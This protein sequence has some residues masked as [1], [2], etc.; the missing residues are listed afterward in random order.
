M[1][2]ED[3]RLSKSITNNQRYLK[4]LHTN[5]S[6]LNNKLNKLSVIA[7]SNVL[8]VIMVTETWFNVNSI[9]NI[10]SFI[11]LRKDRTNG[12][13][14][15]VC[16]Y[17]RK[18]LITFENKSNYT[19][20]RLNK[21]G[22]ENKFEKIS[23]GCVYRPPNFE[24]NLDLNKLILATKRIYETGAFTDFLLTCGFHFPNIKWITA[25]L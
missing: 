21:Y 10:G 15:G 14:G 17:T 23:I 3:N 8:D 13:R 18:D 2:F 19:I 11:I 4:M 22:V 25:I 12:Q 5:A 9:S 24:N 20:Q 1:G 16:T 7:R 6:S